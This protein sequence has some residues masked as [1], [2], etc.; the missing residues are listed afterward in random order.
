MLEIEHDAAL[1]PIEEVEASS[2]VVE[3]GPDL[4]RPASEVVPAGGIDA[5]ALDADNVCTHVCQMPRSERS[6]PCVGDLD[7]S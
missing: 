6:R 1:V 2:A 4:A 3:P 5:G 7:D